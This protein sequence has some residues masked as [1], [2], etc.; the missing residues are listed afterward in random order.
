MRANPSEGPWGGGKTL[1]GPVG[2]QGVVAQGRK[3]RGG[4]EGFRGKSDL[5]FSSL[6][7]SLIPPLFFFSFL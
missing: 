2:A 3:D 1:E 5:Q 4:D 7:C 6:L